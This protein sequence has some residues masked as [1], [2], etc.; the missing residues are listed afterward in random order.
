MDI[1][2][3]TYRVQLHQDFTLDDLRE[4]V[5]YLHELGIS[6]IYAAP[7]GNA[8]PGSMH[9]YDVTDPNRINPE[10]GTLKKMSEIVVMLK[11]LGMTWLQDIVPNHMA[12]N[13]HNSR[14]MD[15]LERGPVSPYYQYFD[16]NWNHHS[17]GLKGKVIVPFLGKT[18]SEVIDAG[19][20]SLSWSDR[21]LTL[22]Y[23]DDHY[24]VSH[25]TV[26]LL[27]DRLQDA[28]LITR[29]AEFESGL[30][31]ISGLEQWS[32]FKKSWVQEIVLKS[33]AMSTL[34]QSVN[35]DPDVLQGIADNQ[36]YLLSFWKLT[37]REINYRR[38]FTIN[39][40]ICLRIENKH[41]FDEYHQLIAYLYRAGLIHG[42][43]IDHIDGLN[44]PA[45][46]LQRLRELLGPDCFIIA[47]KILEAGEAVPQDWPLQG[48]SGYEYL[49]FV[50]KLLTNRQGADKLVNFYNEITPRMPEYED[51]VLKNKTLI[52]ENHMA[53][54]FENLVMYFMELRLNGAFSR[55]AISPML[56]ALMLSLPVYRIYPDRLPLEGANAKLLLAAFEQA[57]VLEP[58]CVSQLAY[59]SELCFGEPQRLPSD[60]ILFFLRRMMQFTGPLT[61]KGVEDTTFYIYNPLISHDEVGDA[62]SNLGAAI[63]TFH[64]R[65][66]NRSQDNPLSLNATATH[67]TKRGE[68]ARVRLNA[69][70][71]LPDEWC[72]LV[73]SWREMNQVL[74]I[75]VKG[76]PAPDV[77]DEYFIYQSILG[78]F[79]EDM[80]VS[81]SWKSRLKEYIIKV[82]REA[83]VESTWE[84]PNTDYEEA[85]TLFIDGILDKDSG[86]LE[87]FVPLARDVFRISS[88]LTLAQTAIKMTSPGIPDV[89]QGCELWDL[90]YVD[91][92]N[93]RPV[94]YRL[95]RRLLAEIKTRMSSGWTGLSDYL[96]QFENFGIKK[97]FVTWT[98]LN[99]RKANSQL[100]SEGTY[101]PLTL[102]GDGALVIAY[103]R[104]HRESWCVVVAPFNVPEKRK[105]AAM[106]N[107]Q[108]FVSLPESSPTT[109]RN[110]FT[111]KQIETPDGKIS[112]TQLLADFP[113]AVLSNDLSE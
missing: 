52:L 86:F 104:Y 46:Y 76:S 1:P 21:G 92:D 3:S 101:I 35:A 113:V 73:K 59:F 55:E 47:E 94:D 98:C 91:P 50:N 9:G 62:P 15:V 32:E 5:P 108:N 58:S 110:V 10:V 34:C 12:F 88:V 30:K 4:I 75:P 112:V 54:E 93:R 97:L 18:L 70:S 8:T 82:V 23:F 31:T 39:S 44:D 28:D 111:K 69:L 42:V 36:F 16:I 37:E 19:E 43:R 48:T 13:T 72:S 95:R 100:F 61:A 53:G 107:S 74:K 20:L 26:A 105:K 79:P 14:L 68:D 102:L 106:E 6:T 80:I 85:C 64:K 57:A 45:T 90:S 67:D 41:V 51:L 65:M 66:I 33:E 56:R 89:Y 17:P 11:Q 87:S 77:N 24:P 29:L 22:K 84:N 25:Q 78:G 49:A 99:F 103:A 38:F 63:Q 71:I 83:K 109:W 27:R 2:S 40:L 96:H 81:D 60:R 7:I